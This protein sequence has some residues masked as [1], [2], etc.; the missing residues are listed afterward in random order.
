MLEKKG[1]YIELDS[2]IENFFYRHCLIYPNL[3]SLAKK[4]SI[5]ILAAFVLFTRFAEAGTTRIVNSTSNDSNTIG[6]LPYWL[7]NA[8]DGDS[9]DCSLISG[10]SIVLTSS[11]PAVNYSYTINGAGITIDGDNNFQA[12]QVASGNLVI[13]DINIQNALSKGEMAVMDIQEEEVLSEVVEPFTSMG[14]HQ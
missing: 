2:Q 7:I 6:T 5:F 8:S 14:M 1:F 13:N 4:K 12:F 9:I 10:Q 11:L 3:K